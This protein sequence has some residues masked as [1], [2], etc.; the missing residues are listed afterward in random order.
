MSDTHTIPNQDRQGTQGGIDY[1]IRGAM[2]HKNVTPGYSATKLRGYKANKA[3]RSP[4]VGD[5]SRSCPATSASARRLQG[6]CRRL[7]VRRPRSASRYRSQRCT[8]CERLTARS[9]AHPP[10]CRRCPSQTRWKTQACRAFHHTVVTHTG[11]HRS[12]EHVRMTPRTSM[13]A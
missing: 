7:R 4:T 6:I 11:Q 5:W 12:P 1:C 9:T 3:T 13:C 2:R 10:H 8:G